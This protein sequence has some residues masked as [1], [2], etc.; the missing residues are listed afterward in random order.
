MRH[1]EKTD[2]EQLTEQQKKDHQLFT[3]LKELQSQ[4]IA[5]TICKN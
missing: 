2:N 1:P 4:T 5:D 3:K